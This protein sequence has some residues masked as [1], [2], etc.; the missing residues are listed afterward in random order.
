[1]ANCAQGAAGRFQQTFYNPGPKARFIRV[2]DTKAEG[3]KENWLADGTGLQPCLRLGSDTWDV[4]PG[5]YEA[6]PLALFRVSAFFRISGLSESEI[7]VE[8]FRLK[9]RICI[10]TSKVPGNS[11]PI[12][13]PLI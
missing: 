2:G 6:A 5:W 4:V 8:S 11:H 3:C 10:L 7:W 1:M 12:F 13:M 9:L